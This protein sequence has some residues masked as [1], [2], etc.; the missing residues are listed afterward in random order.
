[1]RWQQSFPLAQNLE[2]IRCGKSESA[3]T[4]ESGPVST[5]L[6]MTVPSTAKEKICKMN[7]VKRLEAQNPTGLI[8]NRL[9]SLL[10]DGI[11]KVMENVVLTIMIE[12]AFLYHFQSKA[13]YSLIPLTTG[14]VLDTTKNVS[15]VTKWDILPKNVE[16]QEVK[17]TEIEIKEAHQKYWKKNPK[18]ARE[19]Y[20]WPP[21]IEILGVCQMM[22]KKLSLYLRLKEMYI[23]TATRMSLLNLQNQL[24]RRLGYAKMYRVFKL[25]K[26]LIKFSTAVQNM[27]PGDLMLL[28]PLSI[29]VGFGDISNLMGCI[30]SNSQLNDKGFVDSGCSRHMSGNIAHLSD[31]KDFDGGYVTFGGGANGGRITGKGIQGVSESST[32]SQQDQDNQ[33]CI[34]MPIWKDASY[35]DDASPRSIADA[36]LQDQNGTHDDCSLQNNGTADQQVNTAS[37]EVNTGSR[38]VSTAV[39]EVNTATPEDLMGPIP[40][41][42]DTQVEDQEIELGN[43][44]PSY[45]VSSTP[46]TRIHK[47]HPI[48]HV[49]EKYQKEFLKAISVPDGLEAMQEKILTVQ[50]TTM[51]WG[52]HQDQSK[53]VVQGHT[54]EEGIDYDEIEEDVYVCQPPGFEDPDH[55]DKVYKVVKALYGLHQA[56]R[57]WYD[58]LATYLLSNGFQRGL[59]D[60]NFIHQMSKGHILLVQI[61][62]RWNILGSTQEELYLEKPLVKDGDADVVDEHLYRSMIGSL[63]YLTASRP[64]I[65]FANAMVVQCKRI[66][67]K[68]SQ[69][70]YGLVVFMANLEFCDK[71]NMVAFLE[72]ST[73]SA[74]SAEASTDDNREV[75][76]HATFNGHSLSITEGSLRRHLKLADQ[77]GVTSIP[78]SEDPMRNWPQKKT[79]LVKKVKIGKARRQARVILSDDEDLEDDSSKQGRKLSD[80]EV[81]EKA[82]TETELFI[83]EV[84]ASEDVPIQLDAENKELNIAR[85]EGDLIDSGMEEE[86]KRTLW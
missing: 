74:G 54:Q 83:Q 84:L 63:M 39:P 42:E 28:R 7:D 57:A 10:V 75:K 37:P 25:G 30:T 16:H 40:T 46:H 52:S 5:T 61:M 71:H 15:T 26:L 17:T 79:A 82:S 76:I 41:S 38:E 32:S 60:H 78:N 73:G 33:D 27:G 85:D 23:P 11:S 34:V 66:L 8:F 35:F 68:D 65:M 59:I 44:S 14:V 21:I 2:T 31:F 69:I 6:K 18:K 56:P 62:C 3:E 13:V 45:A 86:R 9:Q 70:G 55:P 67:G 50:T 72:K 64:N 4:P 24:E 58:T 49:I 1:M 22:R 36:Q 12:L 51:I 20:C 77:D 81:Q 47:D 29:H 53:I 48:D 80:V 19:K 43:I